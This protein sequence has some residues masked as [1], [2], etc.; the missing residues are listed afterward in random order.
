MKSLEIGNISYEFDLNATWEK[1]GKTYSFISLKK[2][3]SFKDGHNK[4]Q[5]LTIRTSD[6]PAFRQWLLD[7]LCEE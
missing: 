2:I 1:D 3:T 4:Y 6:W 5:N 7:V